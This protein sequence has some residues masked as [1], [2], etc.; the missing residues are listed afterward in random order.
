MSKRSGHFAGWALVLAGC[1]LLPSCGLIKMPFRV[2]GAVV[3]GAYVGG[4]KVAKNT[5]DALEKRKQRKQK[6]EEEA[7]KKDAR[8]QTPEQAGAPQGPSPSADSIPVDQ[9]PAIPVDDTIPIPVEPLPL[10]Q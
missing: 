1:L 9:S 2:A 8:G 5:S 7:A 6:E 3:D 4:K 10:P